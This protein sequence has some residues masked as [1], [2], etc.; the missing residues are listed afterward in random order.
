MNISGIK[1]SKAPFLN[2]ILKLFSW[3]L[4]LSLNSYNESDIFILI[5]DYRQKT[6]LEYSFLRQYQ[7]IDNN[8]Q[9]CTSSIFD[10]VSDS[11]TASCWILRSIIHKKIY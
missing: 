4:W 11:I 5:E 3:I 10:Y 1:I 6:K 8:Y 7:F 9:K 2:F